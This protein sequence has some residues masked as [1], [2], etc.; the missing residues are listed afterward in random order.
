ML[1]ALPW[2]EVQRGS[3]LGAR[4]VCKPS[5]PAQQPGCEGHWLFVRLCRLLS[6]QLVLSKS[7]RDLAHTPGCIH[8]QL[9]TTRTGHV[10]LPLGT[11]S[12]SGCPFFLCLSFGPRAEWAQHHKQLS[13]REEAVMSNLCV[14]LLREDWL[15]CLEWCLTTRLSVLQQCVPEGTAAAACLL[16]WVP[17]AD[18]Q[19]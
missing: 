5:L 2:R 8:T 7:C 3:T 1:L 17:N 9:C 4:G 15:C 13:T 18:L 14:R 16:S 11:N 6:G 10:V 19:P 12:S